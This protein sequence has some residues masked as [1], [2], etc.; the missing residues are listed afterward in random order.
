MPDIPIIDLK[1]LEIKEML[2][3]ELKVLIEH[4]G[5]KVNFKFLITA[6]MLICDY[7]EEFRRLKL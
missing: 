5:A 2:R 7:L 6:M 1:P 4:E 3:L